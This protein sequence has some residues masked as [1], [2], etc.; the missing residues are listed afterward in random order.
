MTATPT[1]FI[2]VELVGFAVAVCTPE[3]V[4]FSPG[5]EALPDAHPDR[6]FVAAKCLIAGAILR[7]EVQGPYDDREADEAARL[8]L[9]TYGPDSNAAWRSRADASDG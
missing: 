6:V 5:I 3:R 9:A 7:G 1:P 2:S 4:F 8:L